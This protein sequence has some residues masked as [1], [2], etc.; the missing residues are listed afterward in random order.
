M[1]D[2]LWLTDALEIIEADVLPSLCGLRLGIRIGTEK[3][4][5][6]GDGPSGRLVAKLWFVGKYVGPAEAP[7]WQVGPSTCADGV[8]AWE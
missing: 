1:P 6:R 2:A 4:C 5:R 3:G 7:E 8:G